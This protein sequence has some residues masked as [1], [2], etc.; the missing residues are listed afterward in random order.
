MKTSNYHNE[1][2]SYF[3]NQNVYFEQVE[4]TPTAFG[5]K[6]ILFKGKTSFN[7]FTISN[8]KEVDNKKI[9]KILGSSKLRF[10]T[11]EELWDVAQ[12]VSGALPPFTRPFIDIDHYLDE[13]LLI[14]EFIVFNLARLDFRV[15]L[16]MNDYLSMVNPIICDFSKI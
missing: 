2:L 9:R 4:P 5:G 8:Q 6:S 11:K 14:N 1:L 15:K 10:A 16:K 12:V 7:L 13:S 3:E